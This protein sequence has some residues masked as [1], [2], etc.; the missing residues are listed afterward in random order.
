[1]SQFE[2][3]LTYRS[4]T[5]VMVARARTDAARDPAKASEWSL[6]LMLNRAARLERFERTAPHTALM[7]LRVGEKDHDQESQ[8]D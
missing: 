6:D 5:K 2:T 3:V 4:V 1:M 8:Y 7:P